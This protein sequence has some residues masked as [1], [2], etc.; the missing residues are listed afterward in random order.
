MQETD[1]LQEEQ[2]GMHDRQALPDR[3]YPKGQAD[4]QLELGGK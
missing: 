4:R 3:K 1:V 2:L